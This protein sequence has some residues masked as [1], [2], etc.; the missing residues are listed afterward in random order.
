MQNAELKKGRWRRWVRGIV[1]GVVL[2]YVVVLAVP[3][4]ADEL[5]LHPSRS[6]AD[7]HGAI[8][9]VVPF[10]GH[11]LEIWTARSPGARGREP[12]AFVLEFCGSATRAE[13]ITEYVAERFGE[14]PVEAWVMNYPGFGGSTGKCL[15]KDLPAAADVAYSEV[16][17]V[18]GDRPIF[19]CG[20]SFGSAPA[21]YLAARRPCAGVIVQNPPAIREVIM[22]EHGWWNLW[23]LAWPVS[24]KVPEELDSIK[25][26]A[27][28]HVPGVFIMSDGDGT[29]P[30]KYQK[31]IEE[32]YA[33]EKRV[34]P[35]K[36]DHFTEVAGE[37]GKQLQGDIDW[38]WGR[39]KSDS[40]P[41]PE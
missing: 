3:G 37:A 13:W 21:L 36:G 11:E 23:L 14:R 22:G 6:A 2:A 12:E 38:L 17:N 31:R 9:R 30:P 20:N 32:A 33:G 19:L 4:C 7:A 15:L 10:Q 18:A 40:G 28:V 35:V 26:A 41:R 5:V 27:G 25:N 1:A 16:A 24:K 8:R 39:V 29:V 34:I